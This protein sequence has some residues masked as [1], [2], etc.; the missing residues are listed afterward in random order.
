V[1]TYSVHLRKSLAAGARFIAALPA[2]VLHFKIE[3]IQE[4]PVDLPA[5][6]WPVAIVT[7]RK[8]APNPVADRFIA[9]AREVAKSVA[10]GSR[11]HSTR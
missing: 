1:T 4:L 9:C 3:N 2:S 8:R 6:P 11:S 10:N 7:T 5:P